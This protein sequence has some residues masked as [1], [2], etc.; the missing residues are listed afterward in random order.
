MSHTCDHCGRTESDA[1]ALLTWTT[2]VERD[3]QLR[4]CAACSREHLRA[5][6]GKLDHEWW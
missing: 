2:S 5:L 3:R 4:Y 6:E 1:A